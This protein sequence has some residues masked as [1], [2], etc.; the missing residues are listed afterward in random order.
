MRD[1]T[2]SGCNAEAA[3]NAVAQL[4]IAFAHS[5]LWEETRNLAMPNHMKEYINHNLSARLSAEN[6]ASQVGI[7]AAHARRLF[8]SAFG[9]TI[10][11]Y[12]KERTLAAAQRLLSFSD[13]TVAEISEQL[14][15]CD[16]NYFSAVFKKEFG[17]SPTQYRQKQKRNNGTQQ[18]S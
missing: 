9:I 15:Y 5:G 7:S 8:R 10:H 4:L 18:R 3:E 2:A 1:V 17:I 14:G 12:V 6:V 11:Q 16:D 13:Y